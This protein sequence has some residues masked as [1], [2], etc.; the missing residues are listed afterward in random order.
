MCIEIIKIADGELI[1][2]GKPVYK[3]ADG[4]WASK[5][6]NCDEAKAAGNYIASLE[7][8]EQTKNKQAGVKAS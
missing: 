5:N 1:V 8:N 7:R 6:L 4:N 3:N 2:N